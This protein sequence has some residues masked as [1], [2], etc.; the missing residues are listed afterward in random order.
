MAQTRREKFETQL[1]D[2]EIHRNRR[3]NAHGRGCIENYYWGSGTK[4]GV[5]GISAAPAPNRS[6]W[7]QLLLVPN[8]IVNIH[9]LPQREF[10]TTYGVDI[11]QMNQLADEEFIIPNIYNYINN[12]WRQYLKYP[13]IA[14]LLSKYGRANY[15]WI[16]QYLEAHYGFKEKKRKYINFF[17]ENIV[18]NSD[19]KRINEIAYGNIQSKDQFAKVYGQ[20]LAYID[21][22]GD[23]KSALVLD[24]IKDLYKEKKWRFRSQAIKVLNGSKNWVATETT[25]AFGGQAIN[26]EEDITEIR[27]A[28]SVWEQLAPGYDPKS[29]KTSPVALR[30]VEAYVPDVIRRI[31]AIEFPPARDVGKRKFDKLS[32]TQFIQFKKLLHKLK[33]MNGPLGRY[34]DKATEQLAGPTGDAAPSLEDLRKLEAEIDSEFISLAPIS[35]LCRPVCS[36]LYD[37]AER[38]MTSTNLLRIK[39][40]ITASA[41]GGIADLT[42]IYCKDGARIIYPFFARSHPRKLYVDWRKTDRVLREVRRD[43]ELRGK[44]INGT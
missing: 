6:I 44:R 37:Y 12:E 1:A 21:V 5:R 4:F 17:Q 23:G 3:L 26:S 18:T 31:G 32:D 15:E 11:D 14:D 36:F 42:S 7:R 2:D 13:R 10:I 35:R 9:P 30:G 38:E 29:P 16:G 39:L 41:L 34:L 25:A 33:E 27:M 19:I 8:L 22:L 40:A 43:L 24:F 28:L 20:R